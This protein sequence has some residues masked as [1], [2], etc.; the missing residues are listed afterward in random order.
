MNA[1]LRTIELTTTMLAPIIYGQL[2][3]FIG[4]IWTGAFIAGSS[5]LSFVCEYMLL[6]GIYSQYPR[7]ARRH[8][9]NFVI[10]HDGVESMSDGENGARS[11]LTP[12]G[13]L[14]NVNARNL[15]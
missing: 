1:I 9:E 15:S 11:E 12:N 10:V 8:D 13:T 4:Y 3:N 6:N 7:L 2:F 14:V 5:L